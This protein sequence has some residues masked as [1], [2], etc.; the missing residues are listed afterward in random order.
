MNVSKNLA[1]DFGMSQYTLD[2]IEFSKHNY[3]VSF[4]CAMY[5]DNTFQNE[6]EAYGSTL[7]ETE[8]NLY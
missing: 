6:N 7:K 1:K 8:E 5:V 4:K 2:S 3:E